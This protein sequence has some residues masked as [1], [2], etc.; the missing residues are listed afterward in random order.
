MFAVIA[1]GITLSNSPSSKVF[2]LSNISG[3]LCP[4]LVQLLLGWRLIFIFLYRL[5]LSPLK[6]SVAFFPPYSWTVHS[7]QLLSSSIIW[8]ALQKHNLIL[9][10]HSELSM[11]AE[12][13]FLLFCHIAIEA[14]LHMHTFFSN[15]LLKLTAFQ[16]F[17][18]YIAVLFF[19]L[20]RKFRKHTQ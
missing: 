20:I 17:L 5:M 19:L 7:W 18:S 9:S 10:H 4:H 1:L 3:Q 11:G 14:E 13:F 12:A 15:F 2:S 16:I 8:S 6:L